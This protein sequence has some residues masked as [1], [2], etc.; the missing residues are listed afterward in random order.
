MATLRRPALWSPEA[1]QDLIEIWIY[2][3][4]EASTAVADGQLRD[5]DR[6]RER[7]EE[8]PHSGRMRDELLPGL[9][10]V[11]V[12]PNVVFYRVRG[13]QVEIVRVIDGRR[14]IDTIFSE[15]RD[16]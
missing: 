7:L 8:W 11:A 1:E 9:R 15:Q 5:I 16:D 4:R 13:E 14:D 2:L 3:A 12:R 10:S 6:T